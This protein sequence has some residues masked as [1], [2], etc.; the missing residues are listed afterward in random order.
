MKFLLIIY[1]FFI[2]KKLIL[3][4]VFGG[5]VLR[6]IT[7]LTTIKLYEAADFARDW[8]I[9]SVFVKTGKFIFL[10]PT[11]SINPNFHLGPFYYYFLTI[12]RSIS[13]DYH[14]AI[15]FVSIVSSI[16]IYFLYLASKHW[17]SEKFS[18]MIA[19]LYSFSLFFI[20]IGSF[21]SNAYI[22][23]AI[24]S[25][26]LY[27]LVKIKEGNHK[28]LPL[29]FLFMSF[30]FQTHATGLF[31]IPVL[32]FLLPLNKIKPGIFFLS[33]FVFLLSFSPW[34]IYNFKCG[35]CEIRE[36]L[37]VFEQADP[38]ETCDFKKWMSYHGHGERC[39]SEIRNTLFITKFFSN[40]LL[41]KE[42]IFL[43]GLMLIVTLEILIISKVKR[44]L[45]KM[46]CLWLFLPWLLF[47][48]YASNVYIHYFLIFFPM[49]F[50][51]FA[52]LLQEIQRRFR[53]GRLVVNLIFAGVIFWNLVNFVIS[54]RI[55]RG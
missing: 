15:I 19:S 50:F 29:Y 2:K 48:F 54:L 4:I 14:G 21:P 33:I 20:N 49:Q 32:L 44:D 40:T 5:L 55:L 24:I 9:V 23:P 34:L 46:I 11:A 10:G 7:G 22:T 28:F 1:R 17:F 45:R 12:P 3:L 18:L 8:K 41:A 13:S 47:M 38:N 27:F 30:L 36:G 6:L 51:L 52:Q 43:S 26:L 25:F 42:S 16:S 31:L 39:F 35:N 53:K 37:H